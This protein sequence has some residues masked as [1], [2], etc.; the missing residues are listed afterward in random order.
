MSTEHTTPYESATISIRILLLGYGKNL[1]KNNKE[2][3][4]QLERI[5]HLLLL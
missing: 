1:T 4:S 3:V 5:A 2:P